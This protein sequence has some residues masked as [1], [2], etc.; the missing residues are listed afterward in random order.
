[1]P[2]RIES[3]NPATHEVLG[4][5]AV[6]PPSDLD[7]IVERS[8][9]AHRSWA[10]RS[11]VER[12][13][14]I[15]R[16]ADYVFY[17]HRRI[18]ELITRENGKTLVESYLME[19]LPV[20]DTLRFV[21]RRAARMLAPE[22]PGNPQIYMKHKRHVIEHVPL[23]VVGVISP[24]NYPFSIPAGEIAIALAAGN[25]VV[26]KPA[27][28]TPLIGEWIAEAF[29]AAGLPEG[30][31]QTVHGDAEIGRAM[32]EH[33]GVGKIFF[34]GSVEVGYKVA[35]ACSTVLKPFVLELGGKDAAIV[36]DDADLERTARGIL[37]GGA[38]NS[39]QTCAGIERVYVARALYEPFVAR[40]SS[41]AEDLRPGDPLDPETQIGPFTV[42]EQYEKVAAQVEDAMAAGAKRLTGGP[43]DVG[44]PGKWYAPAVVTGVD[45]SMAL[46]R[47]ETF[48][49]VVPV[50]PVDDEEEA[51]RLANDSEYGLGASV[52]TGDPARGRRVA[53]RLEAG[54]VWVNDH[55]YSH[56]ACQLPWGGV[57]KSGL[58]V[59]H[60]KYGFHE[61]TRLRMVSGDAGR[62]VPPFWHP[63]DERLRRA[64]EPIVGALF[65]PKALDRIRS[66]AGHLG[67][68]RGLLDRAREMRRGS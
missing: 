63:Y 36:L 46:M 12:G 21:G 28:V 64:L 7:G 1:M 4:S 43:V 51:V 19:V 40:I 55:M 18:A 56:A 53:R 67:E 62:F 68:F 10:E 38:A 23:G 29:V 58:G 30:L 52:W 27:P 13:S 44:L 32:C 33:P 42:A 54:S 2:E 50:M 6:T 48:G 35:A 41:L 57:K 11:A 22:R 47:E 37:W 34:T 24:W 61:C 8:R 66:L 9:E 14:A 20:L 59:T 15:A 45:H 3:R 31:L 17:N 26:F 39:G 49:P 16:A 5:V 60:S 65:A 25:A